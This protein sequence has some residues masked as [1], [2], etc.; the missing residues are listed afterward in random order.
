MAATFDVSVWAELT[1]LGKNISF[2]DKGTDGTAPTAGSY[3]YRKLATANSEEALDLGDVSTVTCIVIRAITNDLDVDLDSSSFS[4][5]FTLSAG[6]L[7]AVIP[8]P[9]GTT[10][11]KN[12]TTDETP[13]YEY[14]VIGTT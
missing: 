7:P 4:A 13:V 14:L 5:D 2:T 8:A 10:K 3:M 12:N 1:G 9:V 11:V 6:E